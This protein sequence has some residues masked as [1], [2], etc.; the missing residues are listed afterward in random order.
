M[1]NYPNELKRGLI[2]QRLISRESRLLP[3]IMGSIG[4][5]SR[6]FICSILASCDIHVDGLARPIYHLPSVVLLDYRLVMPRV[7]TA[8]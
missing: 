8:Y 6:L 5:I 7:M 2:L 1:V 4:V 3:V